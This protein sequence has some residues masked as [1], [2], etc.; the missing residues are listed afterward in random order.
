MMLPNDLDKLIEK[1]L[2]GTCT[3]AEQ[4][5]VND[6]Y[7][8]LGG[9][10]G[11]G[12]KPAIENI[13]AVEAR[14]LQ[15]I[16]ARTKAA[17][18]VEEHHRSYL[19]RYSGI[20]AS[21]LFLLATGYYFFRPQ[22][23]GEAPVVAQQAAN[24]FRS[25][26][27]STAHSKRVILPDGSIVEMFAESRIRFSSNPDAPAREL[28][29]EGEAYFDVA[30]NKER[31]FYVY[32]GN[33]VTKV[34]GT[35]FI[36]R[37][38][39]KKQK[40]T[41]SVKTGKVSVYSRNTAHKKTVLTPNQEAVYDQMTDLVATQQVPIDDLKDDIIIPMTEMHFEETPVSEVLRTLT[42]TYAMEIV[43][44]NKTLSDCVLTSSFFEEG[45]YDRIDV[46]CTAIGATYSIVDA[47]IVIESKG[48]NL[49]TH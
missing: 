5:L 43:F 47:H 1:Y 46:I 2:Q 29:L 40:I 17:A 37:A 16:D 11:K 13:D 49:K 6:L 28:F 8:S 18:A 3:E 38:P 48:C 22:Q 20:A 39:G 36:V 4:K 31:P 14:I 41:V 15:K 25:I 35:S 34:L 7:S 9:D 12:G 19:W 21:L 30:H 42:Q 33:V 23:V 26:E 27:N 10:A 24:E 45:L 44:D 32:A